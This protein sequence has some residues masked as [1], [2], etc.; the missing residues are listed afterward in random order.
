MKNE[1]KEVSKIPTFLTILFIIQLIVFL[2][3]YIKSESK[4]LSIFYI[5]LPVTLILALSKMTIIL[6]DKKFKYKLFPLH[7]F[8]KEINWNDVKELKISKVD[9]LSDFLGWGLRYS[10]KYGWGYIFNSNDAIILTL[11]NDKKIVFT[12]KDKTEI[13]TFLTNNNIPFKT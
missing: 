3:I 7:F 4:D 5:I 12:I 6:D 13:I 8:F 11:K 1:I 9:A 10:T 2:F